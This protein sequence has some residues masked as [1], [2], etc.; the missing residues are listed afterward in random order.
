MASTVNDIH[1]IGLA[2]ARPAAAASNRG[3]YYTATD[4]SGGTLWYLP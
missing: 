2:A 1:L 4:T 3:Y